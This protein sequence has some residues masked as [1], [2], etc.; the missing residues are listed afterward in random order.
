M[1]RVK[2][3]IVTTVMAVL[4]MVSVAAYAAEDVGVMVNGRLAEYNPPS[5]IEDGYTMVPMRLLFE[6]LGAKVVWDG[7]TMTATAIKDGRVVKVSAGSRTAYINGLEEKMAL[8]AA[9]VFDRTFVPLRIIAVALG[10]E[11]AWDG[12]T[13]TVSVDF[14]QKATGA[15]ENAIRAVASEGRAVVFIKTYDINKNLQSTGSGFI[16]SSTGVILTNYHVIDTAYSAEVRLSDGK[17]YPVKS[18]LNYDANRDIAVL[19]IEGNN[20]PAVRLGSS[21]ALAERETIVAIGSPQGLQNT[22]STGVVSKPQID[23]L[24]HNFIQITAPIGPGSSGGAL[25][26]LKG[27]VVGITTLVR[28]EGQNINFAVP[29]DEA[30]ESLKNIREI[31]LNKLAPQNEKKLS[32]E[33]MANI[34]FKYYSKVDFGE[35]QVNFQDIWVRESADGKTLHVVLFL[36]NQ[37]YTSWL[38]AMVGGGDKN[39]KEAENWLKIIVNRTRAEYPEKKVFGGVQFQGWFHSYPEGFPPASISQ[40]KDN[41]WLVNYKVANFWSDLGETVVEWQ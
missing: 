32:Y 34:L 36:D 14:P 23:I 18:V 13:S 24:G 35:Y 30:K 26:N 25:F 11:V 17:S 15:E 33:E 6:S 12:A 31:T 5:Y 9:L 37:N 40:G 3:L 22:L 7:P 19:K 29:I 21:S 1:S 27:E 20:F 10:G 39:V 41:S 28:R 16:V 2:S 38:K 4:T 8:P